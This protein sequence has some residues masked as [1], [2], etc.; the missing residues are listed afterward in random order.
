M[1][2]VFAAAL[3]LVAVGVVASACDGNGLE[4]QP[5]PVATP[6]DIPELTPTISPAPSPSATGLAT[7]VATPSILQTDDFMPPDPVS[8]VGDVRETLV[9]R[10]RFQLEVAHTPSERAHG[11]MERASL[12]ED[13]AMLF[14]FEGEEYLSFWMKNTLIPL[15]IL[16]LNAQGVVVDVQTMHTQIGVPDGALKVYRSARPARFALEMNAGLAEALGIVPGVQVL[17]R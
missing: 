17:F 1:R 7:E 3:C 14:V 12:P 16:F 2:L 9:Q 11:L 4:A 5:T 6:T 8:G 13:A 10:H 15:D